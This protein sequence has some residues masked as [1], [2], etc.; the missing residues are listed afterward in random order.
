MRSTSGHLGP[1]QPPPSRPLSLCC[2]VTRTRAQAPHRA[3]RS[4]TRPQTSR[5]RQRQ[6]SRATP[7]L[8]PYYVTPPRLGA[9]LLPRRANPTH[10]GALSPVADSPLATHES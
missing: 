2:K 7:A 1:M 6:L 8:L 3:P 9:V 5:R 10:I 4:A